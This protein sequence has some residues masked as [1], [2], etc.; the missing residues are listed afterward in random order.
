M[1][2]S[3]RTGWCLSESLLS[4]ASLATCSETE[5]AGR[6]SASR[7]SARRL[8]GGEGVDWIVLPYSNVICIRRRFSRKVMRIL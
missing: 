2:V 4:P 5:S 7:W 6:G 8:H 3:L 1:T